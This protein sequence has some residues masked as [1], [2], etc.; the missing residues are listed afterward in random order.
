MRGVRW[1]WPLGMEL[2]LNVNLSIRGCV[3]RDLTIGMGSRLNLGTW[4]YCL[5]STCVAFTI[6]WTIMWP[7]ALKMKNLTIGQAFRFNKL[8]AWKQLLICMRVRLVESSSCWYF[9][10]E[11][12]SF[13]K[14]GYVGLDL[15]SLSA[16]WSNFC[17]A[18]S[19]PLHCSWWLHWV[20]RLLRRIV[21]VGQ[22]NRF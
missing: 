19:Q 15:E 17:Y 13:V 9:L 8:D 22:Q 4:F 1:S 5:L 18:N 7:E 10:E 16:E 20:W 21:K 14:K 12:C 11:H 2:I 6:G 3:W